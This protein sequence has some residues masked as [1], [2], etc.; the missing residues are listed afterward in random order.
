MTFEISDVTPR[1]QLVAAA[2][3]VAF[4]V[5]FEFRADAD[6]VV[7]VD[8]A[9]RTLGVHYNL[10]GKG[11]TGGGTCTFVVAPGVGAVVVIYRN[12]AIARS[13]SRYT[14]Y[15]P[16]PA[17]V[18]EADLD[19]ATMKMQQIERDLG[20]SIRLSPHD[21]SDASAMEL[22]S[23]AS[24][25][26]K[27]I[28]FS[29]TTGLLE[30][31]DLVSSLVALTQ[32][33]IGA[34]LNPQTP[35]ELALGI[36]PPNKWHK[37]GYVLR[38]GTN[39]TP[40]TTDLTAA[41]HAAAIGGKGC[42]DLPDEIVAHNGLTFAAVNDWG[43]LIRG[44]GPRTSYLKNLH[45]TNADITLNGI[46]QV[47]FENCG[48]R[49]NPSGTGNGI[50]TSS[51]S[52]YQTFLMSFENVWVHGQGGNGVVATAF[53]F[54][55]KDVLLGGNSTD[56]AEAGGTAHIAKNP[57]VLT[58]ALLPTF[59]NVWVADIQN[60]Y[61]GLVLQGSPVAVGI[62]GINFSSETA[63]ATWYG[64]HLLGVSDA[65]LWS[66][67]ECNF[68]CDAA[69]T[70]G[71]AIIVGDTGQKW[72]PGHIKNCKFD[73]GASGSV[74]SPPI[75]LRG[76]GRN[77]DTTIIIEGSEGT[78]SRCTQ[79][80]V[81][82]NNATTGTV[83]GIPYVTPT[84]DSNSRYVGF[85]TATKTWKGVGISAGA[86]ELNL[87]GS[88]TPGVG[89]LTFEGGTNQKFCLRQDN[90]DKSLFLDR[91]YSAAW[92]NVVKVDRTTG[93]ITYIETQITPASTTARAGLRLPHGTAPSA[94]TDG[95]I[96]TTT[97]GLYVRING[98]TVGPLS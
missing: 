37:A 42:I 10:A 60:T 77:A 2:A 46:H 30:M 65:R 76:D 51:A 35:E 67:E 12:M 11:L 59:G 91:Y 1:V 9:T 45:A 72:G 28:R 94:P 50:E 87:A 3:Q 62:R 4:A 71:K 36:D 80:A 48:I 70:L 20:R 13:T 7:L 64:V 40:G 5:P 75:Q 68:E 15:G 33:V 41:V 83:I 49:G 31:A 57:L 56:D 97:A 79:P 81:D 86:K 55:F 47:R 24:R 26:G 21:T 93:N 78:G 22:P 19:D 85:D 16:L 84:N 92:S 39:T 88:D 18:L 89:V 63:G 32:S 17:S 44:K 96:W 54:S 82:L 69:N 52:G 73:P 8:G 90:A 23:V 58:S 53:S 34:I 6:L 25:L 66:I 61:T 29:A 98:S 27:F 95:D 38:Y 43:L 14:A 74:T